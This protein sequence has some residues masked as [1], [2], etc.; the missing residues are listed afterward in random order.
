MNHFKTFFKEELTNIISHQLVK[1]IEKTLNKNMFD[2]S[3]LLPIGDEGIFL[4]A[5]LTQ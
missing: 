4:N 3:T 2:S 1:S 5:S